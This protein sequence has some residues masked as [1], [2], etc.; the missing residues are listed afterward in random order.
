ML[1]RHAAHD[2]VGAFLAGRRPGVELGPDGLAQARRLGE[3]LRG[4]R[5]EALFTSPRE[6]AR[7]TAAA[8]AQSCAL[9]P[10]E[11]MDGLDEIDFGGWSGRIFGEL[12]HE[13]SWRRWNEARSLASTPAGERMVDVQ[14]RVLAAMELMAK[15]RENATLALVSHADVIKAAVMYHLGLRI[16]D[17]WRIDIAPA[18]ITRLVIDAQGARL[19]GLNERVD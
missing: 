18:S 16:D 15:G 14:A 13:P 3:R 1:L 5:I 12:N 19:T 4:E 17:W 9:Q 6:R 10:A 7:Q 11:I 2:N 8:I